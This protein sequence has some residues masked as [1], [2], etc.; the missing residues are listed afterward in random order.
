MV[1][2][3]VAMVILAFGM[4]G[5]AGMTATSLQTSKMA[6]F[7]TV[8]AQLAASYGDSIRGNV[9]GFVANAYNL[10]TAQ[11]TGA[12]TALTVPACAVVTKC[13]AAETAAID[14]AEWQ[15]NLRRRLPAGGAWV[16]RDTDN[17]LAADLWIMYSEPSQVYD[18]VDTAVA[19]AACPSGSVA[20]GVATPRC[21]Y[22]RISL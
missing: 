2:V 15:N 22:F 17:T 10:N 7:Q 4:L 16:V 21:M 5:M 13:T 1:E 12:A 18:G 20:S 3:L 11:Y 6:Q 8:G 14:V 19:G 9:N